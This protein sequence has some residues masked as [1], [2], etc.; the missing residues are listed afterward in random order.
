MGTP[1]IPPEFRFTDRI[2]KDLS[3][4]SLENAEQ[5]IKEAK[6]LLSQNFLPRA[7]FL[8]VAAIEETGKAYLCFESSARNLNDSAVTSKIIKSIENHSNKINAA[9]HTS[10][11][12]SKDPRG[13]IQTAVDLMLALK[14]GREP[15]MYTD[16]NYIDS[17]IYVPNSVIRNVAAKDSVR[18]SEHCYSTTRNYI[19]NSDPSKKSKVDDAVFGLKSKTFSKI[20]EQED[21]WWYLIDNQENNNLNHNE[22]IFKYNDEYFS[23]NKLF[24]VPEVE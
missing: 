14:N 2:L 5:L 7:Y 4:V 9:F 22:V 13:A 19:N 20:M 11:I 21:F 6:L 8:S 17:K 24:K 12:T 16:I 3:T 23:K 10:I 1:R 18:L 15:S